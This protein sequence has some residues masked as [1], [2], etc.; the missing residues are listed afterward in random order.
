MDIVRISDASLT[1]FTFGIQYQTNIEEGIVGFSFSTAETIGIDPSVQNSIPATLVVQGYIASRTY[2]LYLNAYSSPGG[3]TVLLGGVDTAKYYGKLI[4]L[5]MVPNLLA[6]TTITD[7]TLQ[8]LSIT[9]TDVTGRSVAFTDSSTPG[10]AILDSGTTFTF[11]QPA[12]V[13]AIWD[14]VGA[15]PSSPD[16]PVA[17]FPCVPKSSTATINI[18][19]NGI[20]IKVSLSQLSYFLQGADGTTYIFGI[21]KQ[22]VG[23]VGLV[24]DSVL[25]A[26]Y[27]V[28]DLDNK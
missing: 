26:F 15:A 24:R 12:L 18:G 2:S 28:Y 8:L 25:G 23:D 9:G 7:T 3:G 16:G 11:L 13:Q 10:R 21:G 5:N 27:T 4:T 17:A 1:Q 22:A 19:F 14:F 20:T 6:A